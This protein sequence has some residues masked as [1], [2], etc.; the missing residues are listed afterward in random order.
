M[1]EENNL[2]NQL[3]SLVY[4]YIEI[5]F[6]EHVVTDVFFDENHCDDSDNVEKTV[7]DIVLP[8]DTVE[9]TVD[10]MINIVT[11][12]TEVQYKAYFTDGSYVMSSAQITAYLN[13][14]YSD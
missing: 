14:P 6:S 11:D 13:G 9:V 12:L 7:S 3:N 5:T 2:N 8:W 10:S 1:A 4:K